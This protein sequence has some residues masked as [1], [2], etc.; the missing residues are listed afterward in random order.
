M[1]RKEFGE[2]DRFAQGESSAPPWQIGCEQAKSWAG[3]FRAGDLHPR[4]T[5]MLGIHLADADITHAAG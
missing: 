1:P 4:Q 2:E 3:R 5:L